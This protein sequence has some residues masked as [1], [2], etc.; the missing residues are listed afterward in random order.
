[1]YTSSSPSYRPHETHANQDMS[2][3]N[4]FYNPT[5]YVPNPPTTTPSHTRTHSAPQL[6]P[7]VLPTMQMQIA[8]SQQQ[9]HHQQLEQQLIRWSQRP[10]FAST[11]WE[12]EG[13]VCYQVDARGVCVTRRQ[14][15]DM[16]NGTKLLNVTG[17]SRGKR[18]GILKNERGRVVVKVG[19]MHLKGVWI[20]FARAKALSEQ[21]NITDILHPLFTNDPSQYLCT[22]P[23]PP[24]QSPIYFLPPNHHHTYP[25]TTTT[26]TTPATTP[27]TTVTTTTTHQHQ[28][29]P[30][31]PQPHLEPQHR[32]HHHYHHN[33]HQNQYQHQHPPQ[34]TSGLPI[35][36]I[37]TT[38]ATANANATAT[39]TITTIPTPLSLP[40]QSSYMSVPASQPSLS[41]PYIPK[42]DSSVRTATMEV[43]PAEEPSSPLF[44]DLGDYTSKNG[45]VLSVLTSSDSAPSTPVQ[46]QMMQS[47]DPST[48]HRMFQPPLPETSAHLTGPSTPTFST[49]R[50]EFYRTKMVPHYSHQQSYQEDAMTSFIGPHS[51]AQFAYSFTLQEE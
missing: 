18:D 7:Q 23:E 25:S 11:F 48:L 22:N 51:R 16:I 5:S 1:M 15:N 8:P 36:T 38:T 33:H 27:T 21:F 32:H 10:K 43:A 20:T 12:E 9:H 41:I 37:N 24:T 49:E 35:T 45:S 13:T 2:G 28:Y 46:Q 39:A 40:N 50:H 34:H 14:D 17:M 26:V 6:R 30:Q 44:F 19:A 29:H 4:Y 47:Y 42:Q 3:Y 31:Q